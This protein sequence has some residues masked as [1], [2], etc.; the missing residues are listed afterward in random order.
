[1][2]WRYWQVRAGRLR[3][4]TQRHVEWKP[5]QVLSAR[6]SGAGHQAPDEGCECGIYGARDLESLREHGL[7]LEP[8]A[9]AVGQ[10]ALW[11]RVV[12]DVSGWRAELGR[13]IG[14]AVVRELVA[15]TE[16]DA[17]VAALGTYGVPVTTMALVDAVAGVSAAILA[18]QAMAAQCDQP[19]QADRA[20][21]T[22]AR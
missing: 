2:G 3:S 17:M 8:D 20:S 6:C 21:R 9:L 19:S 22:R 4:V 18:N 10:V 13:P 12:D 7:C 5:G 14:L 1:M 15:G 11:G 16:V